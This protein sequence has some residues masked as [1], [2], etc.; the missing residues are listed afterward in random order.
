MRNLNFSGFV[1]SLPLVEIDKIL[2]GHNTRFLKRKI[3]R[4]IL[5]LKMKKI[6][7]ITMV[8]IFIFILPYTAS[9]K[10]LI[11][12]ILHK[13]EERY[14]ISSDLTEKVTFTEERVNQGVHETEYLYYRRDADDSF[15]L[16]ALS[17]E[18]EKGNGYLRVE[19]NMWM[20][21]INTRTF[22]HISRNDRIGDT[23]VS[24]ESF[25]KRKLTDLYAP[26]TDK[27]GN[28]IYEEEMLGK[29][30]VY[31][32]EV[33]AIVN[34]VSYPK[35]IY[36]VRKDNPLLL[37]D[38]SY[39]LSGTLMQTAYFLKYTNIDDR[40]LPIKIVVV[41]QFEKGNKT[42]IDVSRISLKKVDDTI[43]TKA[44]L[45]NLSK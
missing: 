41:D 29:I 21:R 11:T 10:G 25:E 36:W 31:K 34:D 40:F 17:P 20:Y 33:K 30:P 24:A 7:Y 37:K 28:E 22:Q 3:N 9:A 6:K 19:E 35:H 44:Y 43:F 45:E 42:I 14:E 4:K 13:M 27:D 38:D 5:E 12:D 1:G 16:A 26:V 15:L 23:D 39:S 8:F 32:F 2:M 18:R